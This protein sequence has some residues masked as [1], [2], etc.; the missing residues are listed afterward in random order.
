MLVTAPKRSSA[1]NGACEVAGELIPG[2]NKMP[3]GPGDTGTW[4]PAEV[5]SGRRQAN[6]VL[7]LLEPPTPN[8]YV[9]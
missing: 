9:E 2:A 6:N 1:Q 3:P 7:L 4:E 8:S 5:P